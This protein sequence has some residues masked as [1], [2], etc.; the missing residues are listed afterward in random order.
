MTDAHTPP[1]PA[2]RGAWG[3]GSGFVVGAALMLGA[4][5]LPVRAPDG[6]SPTVSSLWDWV[7]L[8]LGFSV[9]LFA[10]VFALYVINV[11]QLKRLLALQH[12]NERIVALDQLSDVWIHLF[13]GI[14]VIWT[15]VG[16]RSALQAALGGGGLAGFDT[17]PGDVL[18]K[19]VDGG[20]LL[21][22]TTT[23][24]GGIG[25]YVMRLGKTICVGAELE[26]LVDARERREMAS[27]I[28]T[29]RKIEAHLATQGGATR[30][31]AVV[32]PQSASP[33]RDTS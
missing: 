14:G 12:F 15:A 32:T 17:S 30:R 11:V 6:A 31:F 8:N 25:S 21:A 29:T 24:V 10:L 5:H 16:M 13:V 19:L 27:L 2:P 18:R 1:A 9:W 26:R 4:L 28:E 22:L 3:V 33:D 23:I 20:I 7:S